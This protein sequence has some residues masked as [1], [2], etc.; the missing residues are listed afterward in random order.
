MI[1]DRLAADLSD[2]VKAGETVRASTIRLVLAALR[3]REIAARTSDSV[4][5]LGDED[6]MALLS[7][8]L[9][10]REESAR[11]YEEAG[12]LELAAEERQEITVIKGYLP[13]PMSEA[14]V[15]TAIECA[16]RSVGATSI[17]DVGRIMTHLKS[18]HTGRMDFVKACAAVKSALR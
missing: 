5:P 13:R 18:K 11:G 7:R 2:A 6:V 10:Q 8:M 17:R 9:R 14:E 1:K 3:D 4:E 12:R 16:I 15:E